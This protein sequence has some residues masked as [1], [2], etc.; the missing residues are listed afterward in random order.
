M[1]DGH[2]HRLG[3]LQH[4]WQLHLTRAEEFANF[5][6]A[7]EQHV[8]DNFEGFD[9]LAKR[10]VEFGGEAVAFSINNALP[11]AIAHRPTTAVGFFLLG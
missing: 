1:A 2:L 8:V 5:A 6:H 3:T 7:I 10:L 9:A 11:Q 4:E